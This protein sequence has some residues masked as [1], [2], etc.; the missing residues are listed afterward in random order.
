MWKL[1]GTKLCFSTSHHS[2]TDGRTEVIN[3][4][5]GALLRGIVSK[6]TK[7]WDV[8]LA[9]AEFA[10]N[11]SPTYATKYSPF[12]VVYDANPRV[13]I[14]LILFPKDEVYHVDFEKKVQ[15]ML[16]LHAQ[17]K[18]RIEKVNAKYK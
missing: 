4:I 6:S 17:V 9:Y 2:Q 13:P 11:R 5:L 12:K 10:Y 16:K 14:D 7:D 3:C 18:A 1:L 15:D 8:E